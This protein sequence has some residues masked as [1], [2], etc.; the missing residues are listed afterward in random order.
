MMPAAN[1]FLIA[2]LVIGASIA[3]AEEPNAA[4]ADT[5]PAASPNAPRPAPPSPNAP[6]PAALPPAAP[7]AAGPA[8]DVP[9]I[10]PDE[11]AA[12]RVLGPNEAPPMTE[13]QAAEATTGSATVLEPVSDRWN[14]LKSPY[15]W[16]DPYNRNILKGDYP[17]W[18]DEIFL[19][20]TGISKTSIEGRSAP[21]P[22]GAS[23]EGPGSDKFFGDK[24]AD[25]IDQKFALRVDLQKGLTAFRPFDWQLT[26]EAVG[27]V[28]HLGV[29]E[30]G[31]VSPDVRD[32]TTRTT[33]DVALQEAAVEVHLAD[34][35]TRYDSVSV[36][37]GRQPFNSDFRSLIF[38]D[39]NQGVRLFGSADGNRYQAN[40]LYFY[41][42]EKDTNS[43]LNT[44]DIRHQQVFVGN[45]YIQDFL[46]LGYQTQF[47]FHLDHDDG[48][49]DGL[50]FDKQ[51]FLVRPD[52][53]GIAQ[54]H[55]VKAY[56][57]GWTGEGH[58][59]PINVSHALY[60]VVG[61]DSNS[62]IAGRGTDINGQ[63]AF[64]EL[65]LDRDWMRYQASAFFS[66]GD[67]DPRDAHARGFDSILDNPKIMGGEF[68]Y[69]N[70][71]SI[72]IADRGGVA[73]TQR[74]SIIPDLRSSKIQG[75]ANFVNPGIVI[76]NLGASA[77]LTPTLKL[78]G[79]ASYLRFV[80]T[81]PLEI[82][83]KQAS[84][85]ND[86]GIDISLGAEWRPWLN[87]NVIVK[88]FVAVFQ[89]LGGFADIYQS[90]TLYQ[91][92]AELVLVF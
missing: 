25:I 83:L 7:N 69:W 1:L 31:N 49:E 5:I 86:I 51:G 4:P 18:G 60:E 38:S 43:E 63:L 11:T 47:S 28:N 2:A 46:Q 66:S 67:D 62:P 14:I 16:F 71:Q 85:S 12:P 89:P 54:P 8:A 35:S 34:L 24:N 27:D 74:N 80:E 59:G 72:R 32:G 84:V 29:E 88:P 65:S 42:A 23:A 56:Y 39:V 33:S 81:R 52:P 41:Q 75:Q 79:N 53:V 30:R 55:Q 78:V 17:I 20:L 57:I 40:L 48:V 6:Q 22:S 3:R 26:V 64:L 15:R 92:G 58:F 45:L 19:K 90:G 82:L 44:F 73:V 10:A 36:R 87:N 61:K 37:V 13:E 68:S 76:A 21:T 77:E 70:R 91:A 9:V 50:E